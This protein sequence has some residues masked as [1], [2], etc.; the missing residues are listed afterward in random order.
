MISCT[1]AIGE[2]SQFSINSSKQKACLLLSVVRTVHD[3]YSPFSK[4]QA[5][6]LSVARTAAFD[7]WDPDADLGS[8]M[9]HPL[10]DGPADCPG[11]RRA[12]AHSADHHFF[13]GRR[14]DR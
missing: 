12:G 14:C 2:P 6:F 4:E 5:F 8:A 7:R 3:S 13:A 10:V 11:W 9:A 1:C